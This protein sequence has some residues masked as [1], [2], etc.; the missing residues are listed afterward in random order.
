MKLNKL[1]LVAFVNAFLIVSC[2]KDETQIIAPEITYENGFLILNEGTGAKGTVTY[3]SNDFTEV[4]QDIYGIKNSG[5][6]IGGYV[7]SIFF[8]GDNAY[9]ISGGSNKITIVNRYTFKLITKIET[10]LKNP[11]YG[12]VKDG[13]AYVTNANTYS[14]NNPTTGDIDDYIAV[15]NLTTNTVESKI[16]LNTTANR[17]VLENNKLY[18]TEPNHSNLLVVN[19]ERNTL[20]TPILLSAGADTMQSDNGFL[21]VLTSSELVK[22]NM[23]TNVV[24]S[25]L[26]FPIA[27]A[28]PNNFTIYN[29]KYYFTVGGKIFS[30]PL[31]TTTISETPLFASTASYMYGFTVKNDHIFVADGGNFSS[32]SKAFIYSLNGFLEKELNVGVG[33]NGFYFN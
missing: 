16:A 17:I 30:N 26:T 1:I 10:G 5:D 2:S 25:K 22:V 6:G 13:K 18:I 31:N 28:K 21:Y 3:V 9:M 14:F 29:N 4:S 8:N 15:I 32:N 7:Q 19:P 24:D 12:V 27:L 33:P 23:F 11:R 20:E